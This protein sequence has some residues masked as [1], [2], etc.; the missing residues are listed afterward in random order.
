MSLSLLCPETLGA[1][2]FSLNLTPCYHVSLPYIRGFDININH[3][4]NSI[5]YSNATRCHHCN[6][7]HYCNVDFVLFHQ[8]TC[9]T[10]SLLSHIHVNTTVF[11]NIMCTLVA[12]SVILQSLECI[13]YVRYFTDVLCMC[14]ISF[15]FFNFN[16]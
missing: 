5:T 14:F 11:L 12:T 8:D 13:R 15:F 3:Q 16:F 4:R 2:V 9:H 10:N 6:N 1:D 7:Y